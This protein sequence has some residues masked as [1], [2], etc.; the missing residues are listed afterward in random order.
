MPEPSTVADDPA[1]LKHTPTR[2]A[3]CSQARTPARWGPLVVNS[4]FLLGAVT[5]PNISAQDDMG[6]IAMRGIATCAPIG[7]V[8]S[9]Y[10]DKKKV[11]RRARKEALRSL[12]TGRDP[13]WDDVIRDSIPKA[14]KRPH[15]PPPETGSRQRQKGHDTNPAAP[16]NASSTPPRTRSTSRP[17]TRPSPSAPPPSASAI[18]KSSQH[19]PAPGP[20]SH[21]G[22][23]S[24]RTPWP[25]LW[26][27]AIALLTLLTAAVHLAKHR[28][29][30]VAGTMSLL[31]NRKGGFRPRTPAS[32]PTTT[33]HTAPSRTRID[34]LLAKGASLTG[35]GAEDT[36]RHL[37]IEILSRRQADP[38]E[39]VLN[40][41]DAWRLFGLDIGTLQEDRIPG[42][43][44]TDDAEQ[45][46]TL[47][48]RQTP[49][50]RL[51]L[52]YDNEGEDPPGGRDPIPVVSISTRTDGAARIP[53]VGEVA[54]TIGP[55]ATDHLPSL[56]RD[57]A[58][59]LIMSMPTR[60]R[61]PM[62]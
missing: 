51:L 32:P 3:R 33:D 14:P 58:F 37:A 49:S 62:R 9:R 23:P 55:S 53:A 57:D 25:T 1:S 22:G 6:P 2:P 12:Q 27:A 56:T 60:A 59:N 44:L 39:L 4:A 40:R 20:T 13:D 29:T 5:L 46:R 41:P 18:P 30:I 43:V 16:P 47:L 38:T 35:P 50:R 11:C 15:R 28:R 34:S 10:V 31:S 61:H 19:A 7:P 24:D 36:A 42:L 52:A 26:A 45:T 48:A 17:E 54:N 21:P 8:A